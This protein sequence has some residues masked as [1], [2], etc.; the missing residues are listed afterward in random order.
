MRLMVLVALLLALGCRQRTQ[1]PAKR[2]PSEAELRQEAALARE[3]AA[4]ELER[5]RIEAEQTPK[6]RSQLHPENRAGDFPVPKPNAP[7]T[8]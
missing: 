8:N 6:G 2:P 5:L 7:A 1:Q 4:R 3:R